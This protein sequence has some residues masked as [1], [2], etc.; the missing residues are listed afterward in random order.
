MLDQDTLPVGASVLTSTYY[1]CLPA[2]QCLHVLAQAR[3]MM[4]YIA[5]VIIIQT[6]QQLWVPSLRL[7]PIIHARPSDVYNSS[8]STSSSGQRRGRQTGGRLVY[9]TVNRQHR[10]INCNIREQLMHA[11]PLRYAKPTRSQLLK[12]RPLKIY[13]L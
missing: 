13:W 4:T 6:A 5:L 9:N 12:P 1:A 10:W 3:P 11:F 2:Y 8:L 7:A